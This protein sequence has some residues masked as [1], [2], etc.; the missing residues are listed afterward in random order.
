MLIGNAFC[1]SLCG[2]G[3]IA[4]DIERQSLDMIRKPVNARY[5]VCYSFQ[6]LRTNDGGL[7]FAVLSKL[8][9][10]LWKRKS[11]YDGVVEWVL[12]QKSIQLESLFP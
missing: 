8:S 11:N 2:V 6:L 1:C 10:Q 3:I 4:F 12:L 9:I 7:C 5:T